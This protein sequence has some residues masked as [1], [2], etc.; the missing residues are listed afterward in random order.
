[1]TKESNPTEEYNI[2][3]LVQGIPRYIYDRLSKLARVSIVKESSNPVHKLNVAGKTCYLFD[4]NINY[5][6]S[7]G[8]GSTKEQVDKFIETVNSYYS[9]LLKKFDPKTG[10]SLIVYDQLSETAKANLVEFYAYKANR[11]YSNK[12]T[13][14]KTHNI[15]LRDAAGSPV[16]ELS[17]R[18][19]EDNP[20]ELNKFVKIVNEKYENLLSE[21]TYDVKNRIDGIPKYVHDKLNGF[22]KRQ[23]VNAY[24]NPKSLLNVTSAGHAFTCW[25]YDSKGEVLAM[26]A[27]SSTKEEADQFVKT[28]NTFYTFLEKEC[29]EKNRDTGIP[30]YVFNMLSEAARKNLYRYDSTKPDND[31][32]PEYANKLTYSVGALCLRDEKSN[33]VE[34]FHF[35]DPSVWRL[36]TKNGFFEKVNSFYE[37][38]EKETNDVYAEEGLKSDALPSYILNKLSPDAKE[39]IVTKQA[40][41]KNKLNI[42]GQTCW[43][44]D[45]KGNPV[46]GAAIEKGASKK[47]ADKFCETVNKYYVD[48]EKSLKEIDPDTGIPLYIY[49]GLSEK[50][51]KHLYEYNTNLEEH[52]PKYKNKL[53]YYNFSLVLRNDVSE[54]KSVY[55][56]S[57]TFIEKADNFLEEVNNFYETFDEKK[58]KILLPEG[59]DKLFSD[60][61]KKYISKIGKAQASELDKKA[62]ALKATVSDANTLAVRDFFGNTILTIDLSIPSTNSSNVEKVNLANNWFETID[63]ITSNLTDD[64]KKILKDEVLSLQVPNKNIA[65]RALSFVNKDEKELAS[66]GNVFLKENQKEVVNMLNYVAKQHS[67]ETDSFY[68]ESGDTDLAKISTQDIVNHI[69]ILDYFKD[70]IIYKDRFNLYLTRYNN[71]KPYI[72][73]GE[74]KYEIDGRLCS[75]EEWYK[76]QLQLVETTTCSDETIKVPWFIKQIIGNKVVVPFEKIS[77]HFINNKPE[78]EIEWMKNQK[79]SFFVYHNNGGYGT[80]AFLMEIEPAEFKKVY[81]EY[82]KNEDGKHYKFPKFWC[83]SSFYKDRTSPKIT[84]IAFSKNDKEM[85]IT[86]E[87]VHVNGEIQEHLK[88]AIKIKSKSIKEDAEF[89][90]NMYLS[91]GKDGIPTYIKTKFEEK[92]LPLDSLVVNK[93]FIQLGLTG[94]YFSR[95]ILSRKRL[96]SMIEAQLKAY[97]EK[98]LKTIAEAP[99]TII[100]NTD[101]KNA[102]IKIDHH[103]DDFVVVS[104]AENILSENLSDT[105]YKVV[106][107]VVSDG[108]EVAKRLAVLKITQVVQNLLIQLISNSMPK[109]KKQ[110]ASKLEDFFSSEKGKALIQVASGAVLPYLTNHIPEKYRDQVLVIADEFRIQGE[111]TT[112]LELT[113]KLSEV[114]RNKVVEDFINSGELIRVDV[115]SPKEIKQLNPEKEEALEVNTASSEKMFL[116]N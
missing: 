58:E 92:G 21:E 12:L 6:A 80:F 34:T 112:V 22:A 84:H 98:L 57:N 52:S 89:M 29:L 68:L 18:R 62:F 108:K 30:R 19:I 47:D 17:Y 113:N 105:S 88:D 14:V 73:R 111:T 86:E 61:T 31:N 15:C 23:I 4:K 9:E 110:I 106:E 28:V 115:A 56:Y 3:D 81:N 116:V 2:N 48:L 27:S 13:Y 65:C 11:E 70:S 109:Q 40:G 91:T 37:T 32:L 67:L 94:G 66:I 107:T 35:A 78:F 87:R 24:Q 42:H 45:S 41:R 39:N 75:K 85:R 25:L 100:E 8:A 99:K 5:I 26:L 82:F 44:Y 74:E 97:T 103:I 79:E 101:K 7:Y 77:E 1:M 90:Q 102:G 95:A 16:D 69:P 60:T 104:K 53:T 55:K 63:Y 43:L 72:C 50:S 96:D 114:L 71:I 51:K 20:D 49:N 59:Y 93:D 64:A 38:L 76:Q 83:N 54:C 10:V 36:A 46:S 33:V